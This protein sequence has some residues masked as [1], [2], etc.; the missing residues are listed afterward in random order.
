MNATVSEPLS[1]KQILNQLIKNIDLTVDQIDW[2]MNQI[3]TGATPESVLASFLTALHMKG[4]TPAELGALARGM[5]AKAEKV[6]IGPDAV[7]IVG[8]GGDQ[9]NTVNISTMAALVIAGT[10]AT[11]VKH[12]NRA[13]TSKSGSA[14]VLEALGIRLDMPIESVAECAQKTGITFLFAMTFHPAMRFVGPTRRALGIPTAFNYLG[15]MTNPA[16]VRS[17]AIGVAHQEMA[18]K[19]AQVFADRGDHAIIFRGNDGLDELSI[20]TSSQLW[21]ASA[22]ELK[23]YTFTPSD[24][25]VRHAPLEALRG[26]DAQYNATIFR[27]ILAGEGGNGGELGPIRDAVLINAAAGLTAYRDSN[28]GAF[29]ERYTQALADVRESIDSGAADSVL[30]R[31]ID[32]SRAAADIE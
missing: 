1:W 17:S 9:Q 28:E 27:A 5:L 24:Y 3:M 23:E 32:F 7:D 4:E 14:D 8:T 29:D 13:S 21:E 16:R 10:G 31:W 19:M 18:P 6:N 30:N 11:V 22:G 26:G 12:G 25:G 2:A 15:P 20:A